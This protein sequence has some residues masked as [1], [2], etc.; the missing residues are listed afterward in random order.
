MIVLYVLGEILVLAILI[1]P[2]VGYNVTKKNGQRKL[3]FFCT[4]II[5]LECVIVSIFLFSSKDIICAVLGLIFLGGAIFVAAGAY[6]S[7]KKMK[8]ITREKKVEQGIA[9]KKMMQR[10]LENKQTHIGNLKGQINQARTNQQLLIDE[11]TK[12]DYYNS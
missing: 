4:S 7:V 11:F 5:I 2:F 9:K 12:S 1:G 8:N 3:N 10:E 6:E